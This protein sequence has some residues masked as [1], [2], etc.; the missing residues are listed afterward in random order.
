M[1]VSEGVTGTLRSQG[2]GHQPVVVEAAGFCTEHSA[3]AHGIGFENEKSPTLRSSVVPATVIY[4]ARGNGDGTTVPTITGD[5]NDRVTDYTALAVTPHAFGI[6]SLHSNGFQSP[7]PHAGIYEAETART[8][9]TFVPDPNKNAGGMAI[10]F[11]GKQVTSKTNRSNPQPDGPCHTLASGSADSAIIALEGNG[12]SDGGASFTLNTTEQYGVSYAMTTGCFTQVC[13]EHAPCLQARD[14]RDPPIV[15]EPQYIVRRLTPSECALLQGFPSDYCAGLGTPEPTAEDIAFWME[16][17]ETHRRIVG[18]SSRPKS[19][20]QIIKWL[21]NP[22]SDAKEYAMWG[23]GIC[24][25]CGVFVL[26]GI[27]YYAS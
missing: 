16:V 25:N 15:N 8:L 5:H 26:G 10:V 14:Y 17:F 3:K 13:E 1:E 27:V 23:N 7:N 21:Q 4:D 24:L 20:A 22:H 6:G 2:R 12:T 9:D 11:D 19:R 18:K